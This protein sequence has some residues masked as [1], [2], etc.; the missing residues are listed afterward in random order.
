[1]ENSN[2][3]KIMVCPYNGK[4]CIDGIRQD[5]PTNEVGQRH[6]CRMWVGVAGKLPQ[7]DQVV[8][9]FDCAFA[10]MVTTHIENSQTNRFVAASMDKSAN[11]IKDV[12]G[13]YRSLSQ[14][15]RHV[16]EE[17]RILNDNIKRLPEPDD[18]IMD[19][20]QDGDNGENS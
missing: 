4:I 16:G 10:W 5:F 19:V 20:N 18:K 9:H 3:R 1:M 17:F 2:D 15:L 14:S 7:S 11:E 13:A 6:C 8:H 12:V